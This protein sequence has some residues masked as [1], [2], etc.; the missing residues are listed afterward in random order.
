MGYVNQV[1][2]ETR[3]SFFKKINKKHIKILKK[4]IFADKYVVFSVSGDGIGLAIELASALNQMYLDQSW[5]PRRSII[6]CM[7]L[8]SNDFCKKEL[9]IYVQTD[10][11]AYIAVHGN[12]VQGSRRIIYLCVYKQGY[13]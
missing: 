7:F 9:P 13:M 1:K 11:I 4:N 3:N 6:F 8:G 2:I 5:R 12:A 10:V